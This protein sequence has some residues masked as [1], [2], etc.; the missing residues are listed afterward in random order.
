MMIAGRGDTLQFCSP[1]TDLEEWT[2]IGDLLV[3]SHKKSEDDVYNRDI[4]YSKEDVVY[5]E[6][7]AA[8]YSILPCIFYLD[9]VNYVVTVETWARDNLSDS[10][11]PAAQD[12]FLKRHLINREQET[13]RWVYKNKPILKNQCV[14]IP[15]IVV[16][17]K[18]AYIVLQFVQLMKSDNENKAVKRVPYCRDRGLG[19]Y[20][21]SKTYGFIVFKLH[22]AQGTMVIVDD[23]EGLA[24]FVGVN[25]S[26]A[27]R[28]S[29]FDGLNKDTIYFADSK[30][31]KRIY[32]RKDNGCFDYRNKRVTHFAID[33]DYE[34]DGGKS[35]YYYE[36]MD[37][38]SP[39]WFFPPASAVTVLRL[40][41]P[42]SC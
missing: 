41:H 12:F 29:E 2:P 38:S 39:I 34:G 31:I 4:D 35:V 14:Q 33:E 42:G 3:L 11:K 40:P 21:H 25:S 15:H 5:S 17:E 26:F 10:A 1:A 28:A 32:G 30:R 20:F 18:E 16:F 19:G 13:W 36:D 27:V 37:K 8:F 23:L 6:D 22:T 24:I 7:H 9:T